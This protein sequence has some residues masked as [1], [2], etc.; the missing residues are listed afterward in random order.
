[1]I[2]V[3]GVRRSR[4]GVILELAD[5]MAKIQQPSAADEAATPGRNLRTD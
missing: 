1:M 3:R 2:I 4:K 5:R